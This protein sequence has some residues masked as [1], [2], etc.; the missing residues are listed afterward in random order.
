[1]EIGSPT[2]IVNKFPKKKEKERK[3]KSKGCGHNFVRQT[4][5]MLPFK[6]IVML[7]TQ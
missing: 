2:K 5:V 6:T 4:A 7:I 1:M 3:K